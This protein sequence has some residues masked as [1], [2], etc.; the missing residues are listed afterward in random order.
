MTKEFD[1]KRLLN[2]ISYLIKEQ[3]IKTGEFEKAVGVSPGYISRSL[4]DELSKPGIDFVVNAA[5]Y[6]NVSIDA[7]FDVDL[8]SLTSTERYLISFIDKLSKDTNE[9]KLLWVKETIQDLKIDPY[10]VDIH[11]LFA[12]TNNRNGSYYSDNSEL[13]FVSDTF[14]YDTLIAGDCYHLEL[15]KNNICYLMNVSNGYAL[16][17]E[18]H[19]LELWL[20]D[21]N[22]KNAFLCSDKNT[23]FTKNIRHLYQN[24]I[25]NNKHIKVDKEVKTIIDDFM[26]N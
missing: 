25:E 22:G 11:P 4:K 8:W 21:A 18:D 1:K 24:I 20:H 2:N 13:T 7:L 23:S 14:G 6:L 15:P 5:N 26:N 3:N 19:T 16:F 17:E 9:D 12:R 10:C